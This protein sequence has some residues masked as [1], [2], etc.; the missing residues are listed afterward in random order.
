MLNEVVTSHHSS[1]TCKMGPLTD[2]TAV[3]DQ[4]GRVHGTNRLRVPDA[5]IM[6]DCI[7]ENT[8]ATVMAIGERIA[9]FVR[10]GR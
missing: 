7:R 10:E 6:A 9:D 8:H 2:P 1:G 5:S 3:V 4:Y